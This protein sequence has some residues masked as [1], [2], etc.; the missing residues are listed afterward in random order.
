MPKR[1][2]VTSREYKVMLTP[3]RLD[4]DPAGLLDAV[5]RFWADVTSALLPL[6]I[7]TTGAFTGVKARRLIRFF[8]TDEHAINGRS[9]IVR[10]REDIDT[11]ERE[12]TLKFRHPDRYVAAD[13]SMDAVD[14]SGVKT[15]FEEDVKP[16]FVSVFSFSTTQPLESGRIL[17]QLEDV[18]D[19][20]PGL[21]DVI[22]ELP[23][24]APLL[25]VREFVGRE[26]VL[27]GATMLLGKRDIEAE[28]ALVVWYDEGEADTTP[29]VAEFSFKY[30]D[31]AEDYRG[32]VA[33]DAYEVLR[34]LQDG[35]GDWIDPQA[36][37][38]TAFVYG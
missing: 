5:G 4:G 11:G 10:E 12:V 27:E 2:D 24:D 9:Y 14:A 25:L 7:P 1:Q 33:R 13:R 22:A 38:K 19:L 20:F 29:V 15:K 35:M 32:S 23:H 30:G 21:A 36:R 28:C 16:P 17:E 34:L 26:I 37:T 3:S 8:D 6:D 18:V 31:D